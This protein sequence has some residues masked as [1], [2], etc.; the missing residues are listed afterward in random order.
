VLQEKYWANLLKILGKFCFFQSQTYFARQFRIAP[1]IYSLV[2]KNLILNF[3][4]KNCVNKLCIFKD[5]NEES[6]R[7]KKINDDYHVIRLNFFSFY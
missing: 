6:F 7:K 1:L 2:D 4:N 5:G 3:V